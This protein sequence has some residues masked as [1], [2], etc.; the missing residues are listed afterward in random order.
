VAKRRAAESAPETAGI[1]TF[2][3]ANCRLEHM[4]GEGR[5][6]RLACPFCGGAVAE[7]AEPPRRRPWNPSADPRIDAGKR[8]NSA[9]L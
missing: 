5:P 8:P 4:V 7:K 6:R 9:P 2:V 1:R 3:C